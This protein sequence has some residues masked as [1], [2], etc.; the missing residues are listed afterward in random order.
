M[1]GDR[2]LALTLADRVVRMIAAIVALF[3][4][5]VLVVIIELLPSVPKPVPATD[6]PEQREDTRPVP[7][8]G[9]TTYWQQ[10]GV[11]FW[12]LWN[13]DRKNLGLVVQQDDHV[14][15]RVFTTYLWPAHEGYQLIEMGDL[16][17]MGIRSF[18]PN[19]LTPTIECRADGV[20]EARRRVVETIKYIQAQLESA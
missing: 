14:L 4:F 7:L 18:A 5:F 15:W 11:G 8:A 13:H 17:A 9:I 2:V 3:A 16:L 19:E 12:R 1:G 10:D 6:A 20:E